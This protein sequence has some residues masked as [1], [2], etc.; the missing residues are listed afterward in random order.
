MMVEHHTKYL[1]ID[2]Y[3]ETVWMTKSDHAMLHSRL[4]RDGKC[5]IPVDELADI[6]RAAHNRGERA[7]AY[8]KIYQKD[9]RIAH[10]DELRSYHTKYVEAMKLQVV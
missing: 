1:E 9:Y 8:Q 5:N 10:R 4:R 7:K 6:S 2:G 3:D